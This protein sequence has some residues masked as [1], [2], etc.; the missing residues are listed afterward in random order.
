[1]KEDQMFDDPEIGAELQRL[2]AADPLEPISSTAL[3]ERGRRG[4]RRRRALSIGGIVAGLAA[5]VVV[6]SL[7][8]DLT[9][10]DGA[11][12]NS[13]SPAVDGS[14]PVADRTKIVK[15]AK[16]Y[17]ELQEHAFTAVPG[18]PRREAGA[19]E[20]VTM[21]EASRRCRLRYPQY[22]RSLVGGSWQSGRTVAYDYRR[23]QQDKSCTIPGGDKPSEQLAADAKREPI[24]I[25]PAGQLRNCSV[26]FWVNLSGWRVMASETAPGV[27][28]SLIAVSPSRRSAVVC[29]LGPEFGQTATPFGPGPGFVSADIAARRDKVDQYFA[30][31]GSR[32]CSPGKS[33][34][35]W[36]Y[37][38]QGRVASNIA[39]IRIEPIGGGPIHDIKVTD[40]WYALSWLNGDPKARPDAKIT[41]YDKNGK[42]LKTVTT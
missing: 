14:L 18:I 35:G 8:P 19:G 34:Q 37:L 24:P 7:L 38:S 11:P 6:A 2:A 29:N 21:A 36:H 9:I 5:A 28:A 20:Q 4:R 16:D 41:A 22:K 40:G 17:Q 23:G 31:T 30:T 3:L 42:V 27:G 10:N 32:V 12:A 13:S 39:K 33:C 26:Q 1:V 25:T 15:V